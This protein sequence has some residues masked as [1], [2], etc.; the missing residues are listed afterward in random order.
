MSYSKLSENFL[1]TEITKIITFD[2]DVD[3]LS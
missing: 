2:N 1:D 3:E